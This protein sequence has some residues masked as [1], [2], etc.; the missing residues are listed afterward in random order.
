MQI[1]IY[2][3][4]SA[5]A[6]LHCC[7]TPGYAAIAL[8][9]TI[10]NAKSA[11]NLAASAGLVRRVF[12]PTAEVAH[13]YQPTA[14][15]GGIKSYGAPAFFRTGASASALL[16]GVLRGSAVFV[17]AAHQRWMR[18]ADQYTLVAQ[19]GI[20]RAGYIEPLIAM[21]QSDLYHVYI[22]VEL[23]ASKINT[24]LVVD[25]VARWLPILDEG[26]A[27]IH[28]LAMKG[29]SA[30]AVNKALAQLVP[31]PLA[32][33]KLA[34]IESCIALDKTGVAAIQLARER[35]ELIRTLTE[36]STNSFPWLMA[37]AIEVSL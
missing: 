13:C 20:A 31:S 37:K 35:A 1:T 14:K 30:D 5:C 6:A 22:P 17:T 28:F 4:V 33:E 11:L 25:A 7:T 9:C 36:S 21:D 16:R 12:L 24:S 18:M 34:E 8:G 32:A 19:Y 10:E 26:K 3:H 2:E 29:H 23:A 15:A 27:N